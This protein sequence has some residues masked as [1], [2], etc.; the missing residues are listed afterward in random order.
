MRRLLC[1]IVQLLLEVKKNDWLFAR[2]YF[3]VAKN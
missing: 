1:H 3:E 2:F